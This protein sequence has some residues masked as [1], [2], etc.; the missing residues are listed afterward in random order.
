MNLENAVFAFGADIRS[1]R[2]VGQ[3]EAALKPP[4]ATLHAVL[5]SRLLLV[6]ALALARDP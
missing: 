6:F 3:G 2:F 4:I 5:P 1:I